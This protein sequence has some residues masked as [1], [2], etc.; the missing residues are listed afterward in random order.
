[1]RLT[2]PW[3]DGRAG[4]SLGGAGGARLEWGG[5]RV[6][7]RGGK[8]ALGRGW[9]GGTSARHAAQNYG[10]EVVGYT[11][12]REQVALGNELCRGLPVELKLED[13]RRAR[14]S[15]D[16]VISIGMMEHVGP[17]NHRAYMETVDRCLKPGGVPFIHTIA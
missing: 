12:S 10:V 17:K 6:G 7:R 16:A 15:Y 8:K 2:S 3:P 14:G 1:R 9:G 13:Y 11:V 4:H 5:R